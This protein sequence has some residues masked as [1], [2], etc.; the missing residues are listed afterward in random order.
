[1]RFSV[2][3]NFY[4]QTIID[5]W[6]L[7]NLWMMHNPVINRLLFMFI[8]F[9]I[10]FLFLFQCPWFISIFNWLALRFSRSNSTE[11]SFFTSKMLVNRQSDFWARGFLTGV[12]VVGD[13]GLLSVN[14]S[15]VE[16]IE[17]SRISLNCCC[18]YTYQLV[19]IFLMFSRNLCS[20]IVGGTTQYFLFL[21]K[22]DLKKP[23]NRPD[24]FWQNI[25]REKPFWH[26]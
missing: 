23:R 10:P 2:T 6:W 22:P 4:L 25:I 9:W 5:N 13:I 26:G 3:I 12:N 7:H 21:G 15:G 17:S 18:C 14:A 1:M 20:Y 24:Y 8:N 11:S 19:C 16:T